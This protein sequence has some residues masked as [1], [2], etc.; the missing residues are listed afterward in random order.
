V[1]NGARARNTRTE[2]LPSHGRLSRPIGRTV[3]VAPRRRVAADVFGRRRLDHTGGHR[4]FPAEDPR[5][6]VRLDQAQIWTA[7]RE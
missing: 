2:C 1:A 5:V 6:V 7:S 3:R 4:G